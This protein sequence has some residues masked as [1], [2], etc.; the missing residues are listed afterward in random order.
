MITDL[1]LSVFGGGATG[2]FGSVL[3]RLTSIWETR[4]ERKFVLEK[5]KLDAEM[6]AQETERELQIIDAKVAGEALSASYKHDSKIVVTSSFVQSIR[7]LVRPVLTGFL[8]VLV[9]AIWF[10]LPEGGEYRAEIIQS[11]LYASTTA[12]VWWF[13][14][15]GYQ[16]KN[17]QP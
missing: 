9:G 8:W 6:R 14:D 2:L 11:I 15:R 17:N 16:K 3:G 10:T 13:G 4:Q 1:L 5:Y 7:A 12:T